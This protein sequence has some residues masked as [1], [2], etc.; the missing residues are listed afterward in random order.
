MLKADLLR[1]FRYVGGTFKIFL[2]FHVI[3]LPDKGHLFGIRLI[4]MTNNLISRA[5]LA[6]MLGVSVQTVKRREA[7]GLL[8]PVR[9]S[10]RIV[11]FKTEDIQNY[12]NSNLLRRDGENG[13]S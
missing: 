7:S 12:I 6:K 9:L 8:N 13:Q 2:V 4:N 11:R 1:E 10:G 3:V 5:E